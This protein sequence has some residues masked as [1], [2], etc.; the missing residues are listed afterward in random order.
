[1]AGEAPHLWPD[2]DR[3]RQWFEEVPDT[4]LSLCMLLV[5]GLIGAGLVIVELILF[6]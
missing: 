2:E 4:R 5:A 3:L 6:L 1:M